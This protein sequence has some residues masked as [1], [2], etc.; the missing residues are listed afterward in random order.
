MIKGLF[1]RRVPQIVGVY[2]AASWG[3]VE[4][5]DFLVSQFSLSPAVINLVLLLLLTLLPAIVVLAWRHGAP[6]TDKWT[7][8]DGVS[9]GLNL[10]VSAGVLYAVFG[11]QELGAATTVKLIEDAEGNTVERV[12]PKAAFRRSVLLYNFDNETGDPDL[13][14]L[15]SGVAVGVIIDLVQDVFVTAVPESDNTVKERFAQAGFDPGDDIPLSLKREAAERRSLPQFVAGVIRGQSGALEV[16]TRLYETRSARLLATHTYLGTS[17]LELVDQ[18]SVD[19]RTDLGIPNWQIEA[20][21]DLPVAELITTSPEAYRPYVEGHVLAQ[22]NDHVGSRRKLEEAVAIDSTF[23]VAYADAAV[24]AFLSGDPSG[25]SDLIASANRYAYRVPERVRLTLQVIDAWLFQQDPEG[26]LRS[27]RF[28]TEM[29]PQDAEARRIRAV[30]SSVTG[31]RDETIVQFRA[32]LAIDSA[33]VES[34]RQLAAAFRARADYD[35]A[36]VYYE[37]LAQRSPTDVQTR[38]DVAATRTS[39]G[40]F[41]QARAEL[42]QA[43]IAAP[44]NPDPVAWLARLDIREGEY[45]NAADRTQQVTR[46][47]RTPQERTRAAGLEENLY[48]HRGQFSRLEDAY[49]RR[50]ESLATSAPLIQV[51]DAIGNSEALLYAVDAGREVW[52]LQQLDSLRSLVQAPWNL[53]LEVPAVRVYLD[54]GDLEAARG[55]LAGLL[56]AAEGIGA[57]AGG[58]AFITWVEGS[59]EELEDGNCDRALGSYDRAQ[60]ISPLGSMYRLSRLRCYVADMRWTD[61]EP[62]VDR[63]MERGSG[64]AKHRLAIARYH[65][66]RGQTSEAISHLEAALGFWSEADAEYIPAQEARALL[67]ELQES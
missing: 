56:Q 28:W 17:P 21:V 54:M 16:E 37:R 39:L 67:D 43:T 63:L 53:G 61:A 14:W 2:L 64:Y 34:V 42:E 58:N 52:A 49:H 62:E 48:F 20:A 31:D 4:F 66:A 40:Q 15:E 32:L 35:S 7:K 3:F 59:I 27:A 36:L 24:A 5:T 11:G 30:L 50:L 1:H 47:A 51:V 25:G 33:D 38:L 23:A 13:N 22:A 60:E 57:S 19:L 8:V 41:D 18:I 46:L 12:V 29:Y 10:L 9:V 6:G 65:A 44:A 26:A 55:S 45:T